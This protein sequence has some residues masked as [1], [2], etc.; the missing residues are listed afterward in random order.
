MV[1][2]RV[3]GC[4]QYTCEAV[5]CACGRSLEAAS[6]LSVGWW[7]EH[8]RRRQYD[9]DRFSD[10]RR[11][12]PVSRAAV[13]PHSRL[14]LVNKTPWRLIRSTTAR[15]AVRS[16]LRRSPALLGSPGSSSGW[17]C[18]MCQPPTRCARAPVRQ[19][20]VHSVSPAISRRV[21][22]N[23]EIVIGHCK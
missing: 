15:R 5:V 8:R 20:Q 21:G 17:R 18:L 3:G 19:H 11:G 7:R 10:Q 1:R 13:Q 14:W 6:G 2:A 9:P 23:T 22:V 12:R 4:V 16:L